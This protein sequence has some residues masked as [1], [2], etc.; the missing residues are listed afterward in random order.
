[1]DT[2]ILSHIPNYTVLQFE[3]ITIYSVSSPYLTKFLNIIDWSPE[4]GILTVLADFS[5]KQ[6]P[7]QEYIDVLETFDELGL[8]SNLLKE[9]KEIKIQ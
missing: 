5:T 7:V 1:M 3:D 9:I 2:L 4:S 8:S 6:S